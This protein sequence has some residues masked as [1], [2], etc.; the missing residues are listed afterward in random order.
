[1]IKNTSVGATYWWMYDTARDTYNASGLYLF[2][3]VADAEVDYRSIYPID[4]LSNGFKVRNTLVA[5]SSNVF[6]YMAFAEAP[7]NY[8]RAR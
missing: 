3:N 7:I 5:A 4:I 1:M 8:S 6:I 2:A